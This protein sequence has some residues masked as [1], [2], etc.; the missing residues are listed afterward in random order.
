MLVERA[1]AS[2]TAVSKRILGWSHTTSTVPVE[3][4]SR[5]KSTSA[6]DVS[7]SHECSSTA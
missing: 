3:A 2:I 1:H 7:L 6:G 4:A 5:L